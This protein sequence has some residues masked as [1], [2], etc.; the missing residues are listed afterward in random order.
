M[1]KKAAKLLT[2]RFSELIAKNDRYFF[3]S[4]DRKSY[5]FQV[6]LDK[7]IVNLLE[8]IE[9]HDADVYRPFIWN[10]DSK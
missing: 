7:K 1:T 4:G 8:A 10:P 6:M 5:G 2:N 9:A 3:D